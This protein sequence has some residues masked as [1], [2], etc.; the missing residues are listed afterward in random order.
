M[1]DENGCGETRVL[2]PRD[3]KALLL[4]EIANLPPEWVAEMLSD[5]RLRDMMDID[6][7]R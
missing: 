6:P 7:E 1:D 4:R 2:T 3:V 5:D